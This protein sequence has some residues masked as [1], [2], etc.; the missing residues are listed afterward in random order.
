MPNERRCPRCGNHERVTSHVTPEGPRAR[1][2]GYRCGACEHQESCFVTDDGY[3]AFR[4]R[5]NDAPPP[6]SFDLVRESVA[7]QVQ[8]AEDQARAWTWPTE[9]D[10]G[11][12]FR[13]TNRARRAERLADYFAHAEYAQSHLVN[14][15]LEFTYHGRLPE[16]RELLA[17]IRSRVDDDAPRHQYAAWIR[18]QPDTRGAF[19]AEFIEQQLAFSKALRANPRADVHA[20]PPTRVFT[21]QK[22]SP[23]WWRYHFDNEL[24]RAS[25]D[26]LR[27][28]V[29]EGL[30]DDLQ[31]YRGFVEHVAIKAHRFLEVA[32]E[33]YDAAPIR[34]L[35]ITYA[36]GLDHQ[37][38]ALFARLMASPHLA[39]IRSLRFP[40]IY[41]S[42]ELTELNRL[43]DEDIATLAASP[44]LRGL[45]YLD[46]ENE[47]KLTVRAFDALAA[48][49]TLNELSFVRYDLQHYERP[50]TFS[51]GS[52]GPRV[53]ASTYRPLEG[54]TA[55]LEARH[56]RIPWLHPRD[57]YGTD[58]PEIEAVV[59]HP[60]PHRGS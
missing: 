21:S 55:E 36:K 3:D 40:V 12:A 60:V 39:R 47:R 4:E 46:L 15:E 37:D 20:N 13:V 26:E 6:I 18:G 1:E 7:R 25:A 44:L 52:S 34:H 48:S 5:W 16:N 45:R 9:R 30:I 50:G 22:K 8:V 42:N 56:G 41:P 23:T 31:W 28:L 24:E 29:N 38:S 54:W 59:E 57:T 51:F 58:M 19:A 14:G 10:P 32:D 11:A 17:A 43:T 33:L 49:T 35:T 53:L 27:A 2:E